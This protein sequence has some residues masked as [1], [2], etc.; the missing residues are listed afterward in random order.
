[1][2]EAKFH[3]DPFKSPEEQMTEVIE[4][5]REIIPISTDQ[6]R[7]AVKLEAQF[8]GRGYGIL[9][10]Y[11]LSKEEYGSDGSIMAVCEIPAGIQGEFYDKLNKLTG[12]TV[13]TKLL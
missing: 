5:I 2:H 12:G 8:V 10:E 3:T 11:G 1:M 7:I 6:I 4:K 9:K 13:Q